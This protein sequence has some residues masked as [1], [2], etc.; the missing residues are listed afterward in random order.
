MTIKEVAKIHRASHNRCCSQVLVESANLCTQ[1]FDI[2][3]VVGVSGIHR[4]DEKERYARMTVALLESRRNRF[5]IR[6]IISSV[7]LVTL[8]S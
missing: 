1:K 4:K 7:L 5:S 2:L 8:R 3:A 6:L